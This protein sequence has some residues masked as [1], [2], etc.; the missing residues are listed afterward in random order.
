MNEQ[1]LLEVQSLSR[2]YGNLWAVQ[3]LSFSI[4]RGQIFGFIGPNG[5]GKT[6]TMRILATLDTPTA[7][8]AFIDGVSV[9]LHPHRVHKKIGY[10]PDQ[11]TPYPQLSVWEFLDFFARAYDLQGEVRLRTIQA[12]AHFCG[13]TS[14]LERPAAALS[15]GM[16]QRVHLAKTL[17]HDP[18]LLILDE[19]ANGLDPRA[20]IEFR[21]LLKLLAL[22][23]KG[24]LISSHILTELSDICHGVV[25][26]EKGHRVAA[27]TIQDIV[28]ESTLHRTLE[29]R[30]LNKTAEA[31]DFFKQ[32][33]HVVQVQLKGDRLVIQMS[34][35]EAEVANLL[36]AAL[37]AAIPIVEYKQCVAGLEEIFMHKTKGDLQ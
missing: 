25:M 31:Q 28:Q 14:F 21:D 24:I 16:E 35:E 19:P 33:P 5:S 11:F 4:K 36:Q 22:A 37:Q 12:V 3:D 1:P 13:L 6:T 32:Q 9:L 10:M 26:V 7:G 2:A 29:V 23:G 15:K 30:V 27:G 20:R 34:G 8:T 17:L 18:D